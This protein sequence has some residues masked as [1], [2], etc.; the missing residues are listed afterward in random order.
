M[1]AKGSCNVSVAIQKARES[2]EQNLTLP[3]TTP[4]KKIL[5]VPPQPLEV[6]KK[7]YE[8][9]VISIGPY[10]RG[11]DQLKKMEGK[12][13]Q[14]LNGLLQSTGQSVEI[15]L[16]AIGKVVVEAQNC[17]SESLALPLKE[18][19]EMMV[20]DGCF[21][22]Q[23]VMG[24]LGDSFQRDGW[25]YESILR[26]LV[27]VENQL[28]FFVLR[29]LLDEIPI[30][31]F[32][33]E[34]STDLKSQ[35]ICKLIEL[36]KPSMPGLKFNRNPDYYSSENVMHIVHLLHSNWRPSDE[37]MDKY[38]EV[39]EK[40]GKWDPICSAAELKEAGI[41]FKVV[42]T[43]GRS[44]FDI[45]FEKGRLEMT[46]LT[47]DD[48]TESLYRN[49]IACEQF[50]YTYPAFLTEYVVL[51]DSLINSAKDVEILC[52]SGIIDN[53]L[54]DNESAAVLFNRLSGHA[55][56]YKEEFFYAQLFKDVNKHYKTRWKTWKANLCHK[57]FS[58]PWSIISF[59][60]AALL[61][62]LTMLQTTFT[63]FPRS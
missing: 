52:K 34:P 38:K 43:E 50:D 46:K 28:P 32:K 19:I 17:Y 42:G 31:F 23:L 47:I 55:N 20:L 1:S 54:G 29:Q 59:L 51:M 30:T 26:D 35:F 56:F 4:R 15:Y 6:N 13:V 36:Y 63:I 7:A 39:H 2:L 9:Y 5:R 27:L 12:K 58:N 11:K 33:L 8:P 53:W 10:H 18:F 44:L 60:A 49:L 45:N 37:A 3:D 14:Y 41:E 62:L 48:D 61:I 40:D 57:Y 25:I 16:S 24:T 22:I 21:V